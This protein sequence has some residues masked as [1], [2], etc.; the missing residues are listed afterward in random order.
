MSGTIG[1]SC[2]TQNNKQNKNLYFK[3]IDVLE[4]T[5]SSVKLSYLTNLDKP[6]NSVNVRNIEKMEPRAPEKDYGEVGDLRYTAS[7]TGMIPDIYLE[8]NTVKIENLDDGCR[9]SISGTST[10]N[11]IVIESSCN[12]TISMNIN[13]TASLNENAFIIKSGAKVKLNITGSIDVNSSSSDTPTLLVEEGAYVEI[14]P[15]S[16]SFIVYGESNSA[17]IIFESY[18]RIK[19]EKAVPPGFEGNNGCKNIKNLGTIIVPDLYEIKEHY[20]FPEAPRT[21]ILN[22][23]TFVCKNNQVYSEYITGNPI[24]SY[25]KETTLILSGQEGVDWIQE[26]NRYL[27]KNTCNEITISGSSN[28]NIEAEE[29]ENDLTINLN[30]INAPTTQI[31]TNRTTTVFIKENSTNNLKSII[32]NGNFENKRTITLSGDN[33]VNCTLNVSSIIVNTF[34]TIEINNGIINASSIIGAEGLGNIGKVVLNGGI[35]NTDQFGGSDDGRTEN[36][37]TI[38]N[39]ILYT[40]ILGCSGG[41]GY[42]SD[43]K[44]LGGVV[45]FNYWESYR[46]SEISNSAVIITPTQSIFD[47]LKSK[48][49][50][51]IIQS[52]QFTSIDSLKIFDINNETGEITIKEH[53]ELKNSNN[54]SKK[55]DILKINENCKV[56][57]NG[58][59]FEDA[60]GGVPP[61]ARAIS[62]SIYQDATLINNGELTINPGTSLDVSTV[63]NSTSLKH[64]NNGVIYNLGEIDGKE[65]LKGTGHIVEL[66]LTAEVNGELYNDI[67]V[68]KVNR[69]I[70]INNLTPETDYDVNLIA[71]LEPYIERSR[72]IKQR[73]IKAPPATLMAGEQFIRT[74]EQMSNFANITEIHFVKEIPN[75]KGVNV[76]IE[77]EAKAYV[78]ENILTIASSQEIFANKNC[79][80]MFKELG[81]KY[82]KNNILN[83]ITF[84]N[85]NT[86][87][88][89]DMSNMFR[90]CESLTS[91]DLSSFNT[92]NV[93]NMTE[94]FYNCSLLTSLNL[95]SFD[96]T[97]V[98]SMNYMFNLCKSLTRLSLNNFNTCNVINMSRMFENCSKLTDL[99]FIDINTNKIVDMSC[100][101]LGC[102]N[103]TNLNI[104]KF[105]INNNSDITSMFYYCFKLNG[106]ITITNPNI[107]NYSNMFNNCSTDSSAKFVVNYVSDCK[108]IA[109]N[110]VSTKSSNSNV[111]LGKEY[112]VL[113]DGNTFKEKMKT[114]SNKTIVFENATNIPEPNGTSIIDLSNTQDK[115]IVAY[116]PPYSNETHISSKNIILANEDCS[117]MFNGSTATKIIFTKFDT[118][119]IKKYNNMFKDCC[120]L[121]ADL[122]ITNK[123]MISCIGM[124]ENTSTSSSYKISLSGK[125]DI[126][127]IIDK[128]IETK[129][130]NSNVVFSQIN[131]LLD[132]PEFN[133]KIKSLNWNNYNPYSIYFKEDVKSLNSGTSIDVSKE[134]DGSIVAVLYKDSWSSNFEIQSKGK[135]RA[136]KDASCMFATTTET[137][138]EEAQWSKISTISFK[139]NIFKET[140]LF[141]GMFA[142]WNKLKTINFLN[143]NTSKA[144]NMSKM[145]SN[146]SNLYEF[147][148]YKEYDTSNL[149]DCSYMFEGCNNLPFMQLVRWNTESLVDMTGMFK[150]ANKVNGGIW[151]K[152]KNIKTTNIADGSHSTLNFYI[153]Y[154]QETRTIAN[155]IVNNSAYGIKIGEDI[156]LLDREK[157][158]EAYKAARQPSEQNSY[159]VPVNQDEFHRGK[160][161]SGGMD[162]S[163]AQDGSIIADINDFGLQVYSEKSIMVL[164]GD[165]LF[166]DPRQYSIDPESP[167]QG[168]INLSK[169]FNLTCC[170]NI[171]GMFSHNTSVRSINLT[172]INT[173]NVVKASKLFDHCEQSDL[174]I[175][176]LNNL[177]FSNLENAYEMFLMFGTRL[178]YVEFKGKLSNLKD[179][180]KMFSFFHYNELNINLSGNTSD[181]SYNFEE[182]FYGG[183]GRVRLICSDENSVVL[184]KKIQELNSDR[185]ILIS[186]GSSN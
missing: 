52:Q 80:N 70:T 165:S 103:L 151:I 20:D 19:E 122:E 77:G 91:L 114:F 152:N 13:L 153:N 186:G 134:Q 131:T 59:H 25:I 72:T 140:E 39:G 99:N 102:S 180:R 22:N 78:Q 108:K 127:K 44:F 54:S 129:S 155:T 161:P 64:E 144:K 21:L 147:D 27:I 132:G 160:A 164:D 149:I 9:L 66:D 47:T 135:I 76:A 12:G 172:N 128:M 94:M 173:S 111:S 48:N 16:S 157:F 17:R 182:M 8:S 106:E 158:L 179:A 40:N 84:E 121:N 46:L 113:V 41:D 146:C 68:D 119:N 29:G 28:K 7:Y 174:E 60:Y 30:G 109:Q 139:D 74:L 92:S 5:Y 107:T 169:N 58:L 10:K 55:E 167:I 93:T 15:G 138:V 142:N 96:T 118:R 170:E 35:V 82:G 156:S 90:Y 123:N 168:S 162:I 4:T 43:V 163:E 141:T 62:P 31:T 88:V 18:S 56:I 126:K 178:D 124:F 154:T 116:T 148:G 1:I 42:T 53:L 37:I 105:E 69:T 61:E 50:G 183:S 175:I 11:N 117:N 34:S 57:S 115:T 33:D 67:T 136:S 120:K 51:L 24:V 14:C 65:H 97:N 95:S 110:L 112:S 98:T 83:K 38:N 3:A 181:G 166:P 101:F 75:S 184:A 159:P 81:Y 89:T 137:S 143:L 86:S 6:V 176:G 26:E 145:F 79:S 73:T 104:N 71:S 171:S 87:K 2:T 100:M 63:G 32:L 36:G 133:K 185:E 49:K 130:S 45:R 85:F 177:D 150:N 125:K 23:G